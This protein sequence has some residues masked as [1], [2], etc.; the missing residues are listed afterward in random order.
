MT[1]KL[2]FMSDEF[3][4]AETKRQKKDPKFRMTFDDLL[5]AIQDRARTLKAQ[6]I[7]SKK[8]AVQTAKVAA[9]SG[10][11]TDNWSS[12]VA[13]PQKGRT[14]AQACFN[15][16]S[17]RH[18][19]DKCNELRHMGMEKIVEKLKKES[20]CFGC[21]EKTTHVA[22]FCPDKKKFKCELC[23]GNHATILCGLPKFLSQQREKANEKRMKVGQTLGPAWKSR[24]VG[25]QR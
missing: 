3:Y 9:T 17:V 22:K 23:G 10:Q 19:V 13:S 4:R 14:P 16:N 25:P 6:G 12:K 18:G 20:R 8:D 11:N 21:M 5:E 7:A 1:K 24:K 15:C 2:P